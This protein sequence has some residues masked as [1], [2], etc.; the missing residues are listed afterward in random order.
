MIGTL[1]KSV[2]GKGGVA[3]IATSIGVYFLSS[4]IAKRGVRANL[5][6]LIDSLFTDETE[7]QFLS[8]KSM[9]EAKAIAEIFVKNRVLPEKIAVDGVPGSGKTTLAKALAS[10]LGMEAVCLDHQDMDEPVAFSKNFAVYEHHR[11]LRTQNLDNFDAIIYLDQPV[12]LSKENI[13]KRKRGAYLVD[14]MNFDLLKRIGETA[15]SLAD[16]SSHSLK[17]SFA[18]VKLKPGKGFQD[19]ENLLQKLDE[20]GFDSAAL[21]KEEKLFL[22]V[23][24]KPKNGFLAYVNPRAFEDEFLDALINGVMDKPAR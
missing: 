23:E 21:N 5:Q 14:L 8:E 11:L 6:F 20:R 18:K 19:S 10:E 1:L 2:L 13:L 17:D 24:G 9:K 4:V 12:V 15:Y 7:N 16:G 3:G 22:F